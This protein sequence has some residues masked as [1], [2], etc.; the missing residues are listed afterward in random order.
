MSLLEQLRAK[1]TTRR[2]A[3]GSVDLYR[4]LVL[5]WWENP[6]NQHAENAEDVAAPGGG[7]P[8]PPAGLTGFHRGPRG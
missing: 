4:P 6:G 3:A 8:P 7:S 5:Y 1:R 2:L